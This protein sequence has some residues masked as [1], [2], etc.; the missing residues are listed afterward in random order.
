MVAYIILLI[1]VLLISSGLSEKNTSNKKIFTWILL[2]LVLVLFEGLRDMSV[3]TD[4]GGYSRSFMIKG[5]WM[6]KKYDFNN[7]NFLL[8]EP[9]FSVVNYCGSLLSSNYVGLLIVAAFVNV[10]CA[11]ISIKENSVN[12]TASLF[13]FIS[14]AFYLFGFAAIRQSL[15]LCVYMLSFRYLYNRNFFKYCLVVIIAALLHKTVIVAF[16]LYFIANLKFGKFSM[17]IMGVI[18]IIAGIL[19][20]RLLEIGSSIEDRYAYY[21][22]NIQ[23]GELLM[24]FSVCLALFFILMRK[25]ISEKRLLIYDINLNMIIISAIIYLT[26][27][28][29][30]SNTELNRFAIFFQ[31]PSIFLYADYYNAVYKERAGGRFLFLMLSTVFVV[32]YLVYISS[33][34]GISNYKLNTTLF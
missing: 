28:F 14:L 3:G 1:V 10:I 27:Y 34:G 25:K 30:S 26:V 20:P 22:T 19:M 32:Y 4:T 29:T 21:S 13:A 31:V 23:G 6:G 8:E 16:P 7:L 15:A 11:I 33:I 17:A 2:V 12:I 9:L 5:G 18:G 24:L